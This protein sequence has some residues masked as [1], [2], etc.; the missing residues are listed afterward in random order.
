MDPLWL[1][2][3][4]GELLDG[5]AEIEGEADSPRVLE[6]HATTSGRFEDDEVPWCSSF[7]NWCL[8]QAEEETT[9]SARARSW[10]AWGTAIS[11]PPAGAVTILKRGRE[12]QPGPDVIEAQGHVGFIIGPASA[13]EILLLAGNQGNAVS[14]R[15]YPRSAVL[16]YR[17]PVASV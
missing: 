1:Q 14:V 15:I 16:G 10:L 13:S 17:W 11:E 5:V 8:E 12:P 9:G 4:H 7:V 6:Y 2:I 3:A